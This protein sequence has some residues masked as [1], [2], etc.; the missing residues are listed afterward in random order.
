SSDGRRIA[1]A[2][3]RTG[4]SALWV[5]RADGSH[6]RRLTGPPINGGLVPSW[7]PDDRHIAFSV[8]TG[9]AHSEI[10]RVDAD[11]RNL[12]QLTVTLTPFGSNAPSWSPDGRR[13]AFASDRGGV[14]EVYTMR[15]DGTGVRQLTQPTAPVYP[16]AN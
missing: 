9:P 6:Q 11:G 15:P 2:S 7:S 4:N 5:M 8:T 16:S 1:F 13:I 10:W 14:P 3:S 12:R